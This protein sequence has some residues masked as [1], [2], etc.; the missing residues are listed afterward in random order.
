VTYVERADPSANL[1]DALDALLDATRLAGSAVAGAPHRPGSADAVLTLR[2]PRIGGELIRRALEGA[3]PVARAWD[4]GGRLELR[5]ED[6]R[7]LGLGAA[8]EAGDA[9][10]LATRSLG[11]GERWTIN[12][13]DPNTTKALHVG[14]LR[15]LAVGECLASMA[16]AAGADVT[17]QSRVGDFG[18]NM[19]EALAGYLR[20]GAGRTPDG[21]GIKGD[22]LIGDCYARHVAD[23]QATDAPPRTPGEEADA[24]LSREKDVRFD[25]PDQLLDRWRASE[26]E[27]VDLYERVRAWTMEGQDAT[28]ARLG[29]VMDRTL[30]ESDYLADGERLVQEGL[31]R[32][33][34][35]RVAS[36]ATVYETGEEQYPRL[37]LDRSDGFPTQHVRYIAT[38]L[39]TRPL[40][41]GGT[42]VAVLGSEWASLARYTDEIF[43]KLDPGAEI[44][45]TA[46]V[47][48]EMVVAEEGSVVKSSKG[49]A[50][51]IDGMLDALR[52]CEPIARLC[53]SCERCDAELVAAATALGF[54]LG[55]PIKKRMRLTVDDLLDA[56]K[57]IGWALAQA[58]A[59]VA[60]PR[61]DGPADPSADDAAY[62]FVVVQS[63]RHRRL[64]ARSLERLE[65]IDLVRFHFH[66]ARWFARL[67]APSA[68]VA[69]AMRTL[70]EQGATALGLPMRQLAAAERAAERS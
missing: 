28:L 5:F 17:R 36:G 6:E 52:A 31:A 60:D 22:H 30:L 70:I 15:N 38:W 67:P 59:R 37:L 20:Y 64:L 4:A 29:I 46:T 10:A 42:S 2:N 69:R 16:Q 3:E 25:V 68:R 24:A 63:Q 14:H 62:R 51:L 50:L 27:I 54:F 23:V 8:L 39:A 48:H 7:I 11:A 9:E 13:A 56:R 53:A 33:V 34:V 58:W 21:T 26:P 65:M 35:T 55:Q 45:P 66:L 57:S 44:H 12:Y 47:T 32:G 41:L 61:F 43:R 49:D 18:R 40:F 19:G 1:L